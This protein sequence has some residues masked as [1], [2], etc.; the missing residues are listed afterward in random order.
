MRPV[1]RWLLLYLA[2]ASVVA[3][4][5]LGR[6]PACAWVLAINLLVA[7]LIRLLSRPDSPPWT[8]QLRLIV[9]LLLLVAIYGQ[10]DLLNGS[11]SAAV[12]DAL[13]QRWDL[14]LFGLQPS[15]DWWRSDPS[16]TWSILFHAAYLSFYAII[17]I[18]PLVAMW[19]GDTVG[20]ERAVEWTMSAFLVCYVVFVLFPVAGPYYQFPRPAGA[21]VDNFAARAA[22]AVTGAGSAFGAAFPSS[23]VAAAVASTGAGWSISRR[24]GLILG[25]LTLMLAVGTVYCQMHYAVDAIAGCLTG[26]VIVALGRSRWHRAGNR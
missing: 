9:P 24:L 16:T 14:A 4:V 12:H 7:V 21:F 5:R 23:H 20:A 17:L 6:Y 19:R 22:Y 3:L 26:G 1:E 18:A 13:I 2:F 8:G 11:G 10:I 15:R 25:V